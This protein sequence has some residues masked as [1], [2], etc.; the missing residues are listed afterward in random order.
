MPSDLF[1]SSVQ[2]DIAPDP[3][4]E[5]IFAPHAR[6]LPRPAWHSLLML[7]THHL[8]SYLAKDVIWL[9]EDVRFES[10][11]K[12][13]ENPFNKLLSLCVEVLM[14]ARAVG[15]V[16]PMSTLLGRRLIRFLL[17]LNGGWV[18]AWWW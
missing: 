12:L 9:Y 11:Y 15:L 3:M 16:R 7:A 10:T 2:R 1:V 17:Q 13:W 4:L 14:I 6:Y 18:G 8:E 5:E